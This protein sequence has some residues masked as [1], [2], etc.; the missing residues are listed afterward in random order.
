MSART[1]GTKC[2][3]LA[4]SRAQCNVAGVRKSGLMGF[5]DVAPGQRKVL[6]VRFLHGDRFYR[7][8]LP[9]ASSSHP[10]I[11]SDWGRVGLGLW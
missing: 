3:I 4:W 9:A 2:G 5:C 8:N 6:S 10:E 1:S 7:C 11:K